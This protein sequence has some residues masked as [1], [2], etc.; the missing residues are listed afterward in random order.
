MNTL[1]CG[2]CISMMR[3]MT[4]GCVEMTLTDIPYDIINRDSNGI[5]NFDKS[6]ADEKTFDLG[7]FL[8]EVVRVTKGSVYIFCS[9][10][11]VSFIRAELV[12]R[13]LS[14]RLC[15][16]KKSNPSP[17]NGQYIWLSGIECCIYGKKKGGI[18]NEHCKN[19]VWEYPC[20]RNKF[21]PTQKPLELCQYLIRV[22][23]N[24][25]DVVFDPC[26]GGGT[27]A[28]AAVKEKRKFI[29]FELNP[30]YVDIAKK[31]IEETQLTN[32]V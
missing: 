6:D 24:P 4:D 16:L 11:Q 17:V 8:P 22:S 15:I 21:H 10:E 12:R 32:E 18:F 20:E 25:G 14:T 29:A 2:D 26:V 28:I 19:P 31:R 13:E 9:T 23:S 27:T 3:E 30:E 1:R 7:V 5:R